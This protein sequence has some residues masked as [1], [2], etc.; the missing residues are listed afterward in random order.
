M[1]DELKRQTSGSTITAISG[2]GIDDNANVLC[3]CPQPGPET[4]AVEQVLGAETKQ[5]V[6]E[7]DM[8]LPSNKPSIQQVIDVYVKDVCISDVDVIPDKVII[9]GNLE[10][11]VMYVADLP[12]EPVHAYER[13]HVRFTRDIVLEGAEPGMDA[14]ADVNVEYINYDFDCWCDRRKV[15]IT[16]VLKFWARVTTTTS[17]DVYALTPIN[18][19][20]PVE[21]IAGPAG[22]YGGYAPENMFVSGMQPVA[23][24]TMGPV[25]GTATVIGTKVNVRTGPGTTFPVVTQVNSG[26][27]VTIKDG[28]FGW[29]R[30]VL[31]DGTTTGWIAGWL[32]QTTSGTV[33]STPKG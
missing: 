29:N 8:I 5:R 13:K 14:T 33:P 9:R 31:S 22:Y 4:I 28:A 19:M 20:G 1:T 24:T 16:I 6:V 23:G 12:D 15:H 25:T 11:K 21:A 26:A 18:E 17:M 30:V 2:T 7:F 10:V 32:L 3:G 27:T